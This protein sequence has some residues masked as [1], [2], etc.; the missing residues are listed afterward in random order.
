[1]SFIK[2]PDAVLHFSNPKYKSYSGFLFVITD[3]TLACSVKK[4]SIV[5]NYPNYFIANDWSVIKNS[6]KIIGK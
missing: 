4:W 2:I 3:N 1:M 5:T 6:A